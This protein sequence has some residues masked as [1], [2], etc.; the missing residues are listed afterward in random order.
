MD[1][2]NY[3]II[4]CISIFESANKLGVQ[5]GFLFQQDNAPAIKVATFKCFLF[6][7]I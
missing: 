1:S 6:K 7:E 3:V 2:V 4:L 5:E